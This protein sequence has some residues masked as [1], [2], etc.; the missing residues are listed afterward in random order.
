[1]TK[2]SVGFLLLLHYLIMNG[3]GATPHNP[4]ITMLADSAK[5]RALVLTSIV[6]IPANQYRTYFQQGSIASQGVVDIKAPHCDLEIKNEYRRPKIIK[7]SSFDIIGIHT[8]KE[9]ITAG[10]NRSVSSFGDKTL[11]TTHL[12]IKSR[13]NTD[14]IRLNCAKMDAQFVEGHIT[15]EEFANAVG[16]Y[17]NLK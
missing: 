7:Q 6:S 14:V 2:L 1:M 5:N 11:F 16:S 9:N 4:S 12:F 8:E 3:C 13:I 10:A 17:F 15:M